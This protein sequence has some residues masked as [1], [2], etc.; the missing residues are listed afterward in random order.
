MFQPLHAVKLL[1][2]AMFC[3]LGACAGGPQLLPETK[4]LPERVELADVPFFQLSDAQ[5]GPSALAALLNHYGVIS[6]PG[7]VDERI[8]QLAKDLTSPEVAKY[9]TDNFAGSVIPVAGSK[10]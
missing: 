3:L 6:S 1:S 4:R 2:I 9:I 10:P 5:G 7:L 8:Q